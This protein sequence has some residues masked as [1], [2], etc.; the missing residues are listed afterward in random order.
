VRNK[1]LYFNRANHPISKDEWDDKRADPAYRQVALYDNAVVKV[2]VAW[3]GRVTNAQNLLPEYYPVFVLLVKNYTSEG[4]LVDDPVDNDRTFPDEVS[5]RA[6]FAKFVERWTDAS[7]DEIAKSILSEPEPEA[8][9]P[10]DRPA[11]DEG[12]IAGGAW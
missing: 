2:E 3:S 11:S 10:P 1:T 6:A 12:E 9:P 8:P 5:A 4:W 7:P